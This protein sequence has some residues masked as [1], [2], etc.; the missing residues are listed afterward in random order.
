MTSAPAA[1]L[2]GMRQQ[3][4]PAGYLDEL[5]EQL[6]KT[7]VLQCARSCTMVA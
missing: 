7:L 5:V 4:V 6:G 2:I 3:P 1:G